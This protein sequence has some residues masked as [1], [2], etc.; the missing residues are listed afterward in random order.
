MGTLYG[1][2]WNI[3]FEAGK[4]VLSHGGGMPGYK[5]FVTVIPEDSIGIV[6]VTNKITYL[7]EELAGVIINY[8]TTDTMNW[9]EADKNM[10][11]KNF[12]FS[13]I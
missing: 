9:Q 3:G 13:Q 8:L 12:N 4:K 6:I 10:Y 11:G 1:F 5:S 7:N 2:G